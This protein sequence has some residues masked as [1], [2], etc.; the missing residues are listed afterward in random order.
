M[1]DS[2]S[3]PLDFAPVDFAAR[4]VASAFAEVRH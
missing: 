1:E 4:D 2:G 3:R